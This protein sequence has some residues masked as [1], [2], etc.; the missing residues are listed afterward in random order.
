MFSDCVRSDRMKDNES[1]NKER[2]MKAANHDTCQTTMVG[3][4]AM[5]G[6][7]GVL[8]LGKL[9]AARMPVIVP[10]M[11]IRSYQAH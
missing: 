1:L 9:D 7:D 5:V 4:D 8:G 6:V 10:A 3:E 11:V 2:D